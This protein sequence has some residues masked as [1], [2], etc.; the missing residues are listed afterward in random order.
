MYQGADSARLG[1][2]VTWNVTG[3]PRS[4]SKVG[5]ALTGRVPVMG[6]GLHTATHQGSVAIGEFLVYA[7]DEECQPVSG[8]FALFDEA[9]PIP[10]G[11]AYLGFLLLHCGGASFDVTV[12]A[13]R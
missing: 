11:A 7:Y 3:T 2:T 12:T 6:D 13:P 4:I 8:G 5:G 1:A 9:T 10:A